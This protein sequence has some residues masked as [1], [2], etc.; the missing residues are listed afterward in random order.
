MKWLMA[1]GRNWKVSE[2]RRVAVL[3]LPCDSPAAGLVAL[4]VVIGDL[5]DPRATDVDGHF[6]ALIRYARQYLG[7]C[8]DCPS[9]CRP[10]DQRC[11]FSTESNGKLRHVSDG[12]YGPIV[13]VGD[14]VVPTI[15]LKKKT[16]LVLLHPPA[17]REYHVSTAPPISAGRS[18]SLDPKPYTALA[19][20]LELLV[21]NLHQTFSGACFAGR[22]AGDRATQDWYGQ[23]HLDAGG[24]EKPLRDLLTIQGWGAPGVSRMTSFNTRTGRFDRPSSFHQLVIA[25]GGAALSK[26]LETREFDRADVIAVSHRSMSDVDARS[27]GERFAA[28]RQWYEVDSTP[29]HPGSEVPR[30]IALQVLRR[31]G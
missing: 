8:R 26:V 15:T 24:C 5:A 31:R 10:H 23:V 9:R 7:A 6:N 16:G 13:G 4:G 30:G 18:G 3:S 27:V 1:V 19:N 11:G 20:G 2:R 14:G 17:G 21:P 29:L 22:L 12:L 28:M 25:D